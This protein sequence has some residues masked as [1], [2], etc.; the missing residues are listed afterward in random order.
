MQPLHN[1]KVTLKATFQFKKNL[2]FIILVFIKF[3][4]QKWLINEW[5]KEATKKSAITTNIL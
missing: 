5:Y 4:Y 2:H 3:F 1:I